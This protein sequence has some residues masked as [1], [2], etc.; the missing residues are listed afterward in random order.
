VLL[1]RCK[2]ALMAFFRYCWEVFRGEDREL[3]HVAEGNR[4]IYEELN[5]GKE[6]N[7]PGECAEV[8]SRLW[9]IVTRDG[10]GSFKRA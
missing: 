5:G 7:G 1:G 10:A 8:P 9:L 3:C 4:M 2:S 6:R